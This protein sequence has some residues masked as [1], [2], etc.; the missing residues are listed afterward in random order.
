[1]THLHEHRFLKCPYSRARTYL[2]DA[3]ESIAQNRDPQ[4]LTLRVP[5]RAGDLGLKKDVIVTYSPANDP[6]HFDEPWH[7]RWKPDGGGPYP[8][9]EGE[10]TIRADEDY[11]TSILE[12]TGAYTAPL[13]IAG[14]AFDAVAGSKIAAATAQDLLR[15]IGEA[16]ERRYRDEEA[17][18]S[19]TRG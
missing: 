3:L 13:G 19:P 2:R 6:M 12:L 17:V 16:M 14:A 8:E 9:F 11:P 5:F 15:T 1:M 18:K 10:L 7:V 4:K